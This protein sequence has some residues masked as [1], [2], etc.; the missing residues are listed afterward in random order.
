[1]TAKP[2][3]D[4]FRFS[5]AARLGIGF[6]TA[7]L[8]L[9]LIGMAGGTAAVLMDG[10]WIAALVLGVTVAFFVPLAGIVLRDCRMKWG[11]R[12]SLGAGE[13]WLRLP[14]GRL[15]F[16]PAPALSGPLAYASIKAIE[17]REEATHAMG[18][19]TINRVYAIRLKSRGVILIGEDR[20]I[21]KTLDYT[22]L[23]GDAARALARK[24]GTGMRQLPLARGDGGFLTLWGASRPDWPGAEGADQISEADERAIRR[25]VWITQM[26]PVFAFAIVQLVLMLP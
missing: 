8:W 26:L 12:V 2:P 20:P 11:W 6:T 1:M 25:S 15:L 10:E 14:H 24:A 23:A 3:N 16:G 19:T 17:W 7:L 4:D 18:L 9:L 21:P 22:T 5:L 13:A